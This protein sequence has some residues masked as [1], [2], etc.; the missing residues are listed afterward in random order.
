MEPLPPD[1]SS[2]ET[3]CSA[4]TTTSPITPG[5]GNIGSCSSRSDSRQFPNALP[6][7]ISLAQ[8]HHA[9]PHPGC[10]LPSSIPTPGHANKDQEAR[11]HLQ[12]IPRVSAADTQSDGEVEEI[13]TTPLFTHKVRMVMENGRGPLA[14]AG[15]AS[16]IFQ[17]YGLLGVRERTY[18]SRHP[19]MSNTLSVEQNLVYANMNAPWSVYIC[20]SQGTGKSHSLSCLLENSLLT[21]SL[22]GNNPNP[23]AGLVFH[24]DRFT[25]YESTQLCEAAYLCSA[26][27]Q[28]RVLV[29]PSN[30]HA[31]RKLYRH[32]PGLPAA[33]PRPEV[34]PLYFQEHQLNVSRLM[35]LMAANGE[36]GVPL[37][38]EVL[39]KILRDMS[40]ENKGEG[41]LDYLD[42][43]QRL[44]RQAF[45]A[46]QR[47]PL[48]MRLALLESFLA[49]K[50][51]SERSTAR[52]NRLFNSAQGTL[53]IVDLSCP[54]VNENDACALFTICLSLFMEHRG[55]CGRIIA[56]DEA[57]KF[58]TQSGEAEKLTE[59]LTSI[60]RQ[61][62]HLGTRIIIAT[63]EPTLAP[64]LLD[65][66][67]VSIVHR[68]NSPAWFEV[69]R[70]HLA[71]AHLC[72]DH[73]DPALFEMIIGLKTGQALVFCPSAML[74]ASAEEGV[75]RLNDAFI[76]IQIRNRVTADGG[77][78]ILASD[79]IQRIERE[80]IPM[81]ELIV[82]FS[83][84]PR[85]LK[86]VAAPERFTS[87]HQ[88]HDSVDASSSAVTNDTGTQPSL[89]DNKAR[90]M[91]E[92]QDEEF[93]DTLSSAG[94]DDTHP[95]VTNNAA[96]SPSTINDHGPERRYPLRTSRPRAIM[97][98]PVPAVAE[99]DPQAV[100]SASR[101]RLAPASAPAKSVTTR[102]RTN[103]SQDVASV[104]VQDAITALLKDRPNTLKFTAVREQ[105]ARSAGLPEGFFTSTEIWTRWSRCKIRELVVSIFLYVRLAS[106][107]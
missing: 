41:R 86:A 15:S 24:Y 82:P 74:D 11:N 30:V 12:L 73:R 103:I 58:L 96:R 22:A 27:V 78:S 40:T 47:T 76:R 31:M 4:S 20:G 42:F 97:A 9:H 107:S 26:G 56:L 44:A 36:K 5:T 14:A 2:V 48:E 106:V 85:S 59:Q 55:D 28:V 13:R 89:R 50:Q 104:H 72:H 6:A 83:A 18:G 60:V 43:K 57:H 92:D 46:Q 79:D 10:I 23:L 53:T 19:D 66:C 84:A 94:T 100:A 68:F 35:T 33:T 38:M 51:Q 71:G 75:R 62:R 99:P 49:H 77:R 3:G 16:D 52:L 87:Y 39:F 88:N 101:P 70:R 80:D 91:S 37:Y 1:D 93:V 61:Q 69:L 7:Q 95:P 17:Q 32:L 21:S 8:H 102:S 105:A 65:L 45:S 63:Q 90:L 25:S 81:E 34:I 64:S 67:N 98:S 54:F 29:S